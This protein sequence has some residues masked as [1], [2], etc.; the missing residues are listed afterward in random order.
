[1]SF[2]I[3]L[4]T[5]QE[6]LGEL[7]SSAELRFGLYTDTDGE[8]GTGGWGT[9]DGDFDNQSPGATADSGF[10]FRTP[11]GPAAEA[12]SFASRIVY[13]GPNTD[14]ILGGS[15]GNTIRVEDGFGNLFDDQTHTFTITLE[16]IAGA[17][18]EDIQ[19]TFDIDGTSFTRTTEGEGLPA[20]GLGSFDYFAIVANQDQDFAIDNFSI[21]AIPVPTP[22][23][24][25]LLGLAGI[26]STTR[27]RR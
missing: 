2:D 19:I 12:S 27:R 6:D 5:D 9:S 22:G 16:R 3:R 10:L 17:A 21:A 4:I 24:A 15:E 1:M 20:T 14:A 7:T 11:M 13:E 26:A 8:L 23:A 18:G 25:A